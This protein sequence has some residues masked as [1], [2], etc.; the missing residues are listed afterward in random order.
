[1][2]DR[3]HEIRFQPLAVAELRVLLLEL[4]PGL[5]EAL[6]HPV[7]GGRELADLTGPALR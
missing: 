3:V 1:M 2:R 4:D 5:L 7:E 6:G